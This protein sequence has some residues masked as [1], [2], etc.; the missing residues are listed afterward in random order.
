MSA[1]LQ[2]EAMKGYFQSMFRDT[3]L[4]KPSPAPEPAPEAA[5]PERA[6]L[7]AREPLPEAEPEA[8]PVLEAEPETEE[9]KSSA[10]SLPPFRPSGLLPKPGL[11]PR[12]RPSQRLRRL[13]RL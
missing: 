9:R 7:P 5:A 3:E 1:D 4:K 6:P 8:R 2:L 11:R 13:R 10:S 12:R